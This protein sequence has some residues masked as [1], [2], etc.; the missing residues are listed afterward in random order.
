MLNL[1]ER[2][3]RRPVRHPR[4]FFLGCLSY[5]M[6]ARH[7][8]AEQ[9]LAQIRESDAARNPAISSRLALA[10]AAI[11]MQH[12][13]ARRA[14]DLL[15]PLVGR[16]DES[17]FLH[18]VHLTTLVS[19]YAG[20]RPFDR[21]V[22]APRCE[23][24]AAGRSKERP[25]YRLRRAH[26]RPHCW[27]KARVQEAARLGAALLARSEVALGRR[28]IS[29]NLCAATLGAAYYELDM[30]DEAR[31]VLANRSGIL[32]SSAPGVMVSL[33]CAGRG[34][35]SA[36]VAGCR[37]RIRAL[38][39]CPLPQPAAGPPVAYM[40]SEEIVILL[41][42]GRARTRRRACRSN[43]RSSRRRTATRWRCGPR[44]RRSP[45]WRARASQ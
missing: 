15:E 7:T 29:A 45:H 31:E 38:A 9:W 20:V 34:W 25:R 3:P 22:P 40:L 43:W 5:S 4:L 24:G 26:A 6:T 13:D 10:D 21:R 16:P 23:P 41:G 8:K 1:L 17:R 27:S 35:T 12:D 33:R 42:K 14:I 37:A 32:Q 44:F 2:C 28:S 18:Y 39:R 30:I 19:A 36:G 11:A